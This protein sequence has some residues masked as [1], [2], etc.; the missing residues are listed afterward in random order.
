MK[1]WI[2]AILF[3]ACAGLFTANGSFAQ[4]ATPEA[5]PQ[6][7][8]EGVASSTTAVLG[9]WAVTD[10]FSPGPEQCTAEGASTDEVAAEILALESRVDPALTSNGVV[11]ILAGAPADQGAIDGVLATLTQF[12]ACNNAGSRASLVSVMTPQGVAELYDL[13]LSAGEEAVRAGV[14]AALTPGEPRPAEELAGIDGIPSIV[15]LEDGRVAALV[16]NTD[17]A[18]AGG[19]QVLDLFIFVNQDGQY[20][21]DSFIGDPFDMIEGYGFEKG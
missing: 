6:A 16:L 19:D 15:Q 12:W 18:I 13:D 4:D 21:V 2:A 3:L 17:P 11:E 7:S 1:K 5:T 14:A 8:P 10:P 20:M 9:A